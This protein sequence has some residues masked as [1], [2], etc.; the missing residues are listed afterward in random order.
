MLI[1]FHDKNSYF[2]HYM[3]VGSNYSNHNDNIYDD[4]NDNINNDNNDIINNDNNDDSIYDS[5]N[6]DDG[7]MKIMIA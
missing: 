2:H 4:N 1:P 5:N 7:I 3:L 6:D